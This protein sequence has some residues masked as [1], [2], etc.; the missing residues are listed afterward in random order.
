MTQLIALAKQVKRRLGKLAKPKPFVSKTRRIERVAMTERICAMT[1]DDG[2]YDLPCE[3]DNFGGRSLTDVLLDTLAA[4]G[5]HGTFDVIGDTSENYPDTCGDA[6]TPAWGGVQFD[7]YPAY[8]KDAHGGAVH[9]GRLIRRMLDE[10]HQI[11]NHG[12]RHLLFG[13]KA[14]VYGKRTT[15][16]G[17]DAV[18]AD[19]SRLDSLM[20]EQYGYTMTMARPPHYVDNIRGGYTS[21]DIYDALGY[22]YMAAS[23]DGAGWLPGATLE[24]EV[25][26]M[27]EPMRR[28]LEA[29]PD[30]FCG[31]IIFQKDGCNM[32]HRTPVAF[33]L[34][35]QLEL[36]KSYGYRVVSVEELTEHSMFADLLPTH[37]LYAKL[38]ALAKEK[39]VAYSDNT[40]K[41]E[42][43]MTN[44]EFAHL[45]APMPKAVMTR[46]Q[47]DEAAVGYA[48]ANG[49]LP[50]PPHRN[51]PLRLP[52]TPAA[53]RLFAMPPKS[54]LRADVFAALRSDACI[55]R[56]EKHG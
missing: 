28:A 51:A 29:D 45:V 19:L 44:L 27:V 18:L 1:F 4:Y 5:A 23:F 30:V 33:A 2:P 12:Y 13:K 37:P 9:A 6:G 20:K 42:R 54:A 53:A 46:R 40:V 11:T 35:R 10:G 3:P 52:L 36:L 34:Q 50:S 14:W 7:H 31:Q 22:A 48:I 32:L 8:G 56:G 16:D 25:N 39:P 15:L 21:Y 17:A 26:A 47:K 41:P 24:D 49:L 55:T 38:A 43:T